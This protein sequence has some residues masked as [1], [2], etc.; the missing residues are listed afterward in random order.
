MKEIFDYLRK[1]SGGSL[2][3][4]QVVA[5]DQLIAIASDTVADML[6]IA[7]DLVKQVSNSGIN[8]ICGFEGLKLK[9]YDDS[10][11]VWTIGFGTTIYPNGIKVKKGDICTLEQAKAYMAHDLKKFESAVNSAVAVPINQ[12]QFDALVSLAYNIGTGAFKESTLLKK[13][14]ESDYK[15][16][17]AQF[18]VW[19]KA[20]GKVMPGL[21]NRRAV[22]RKL[23]EKAL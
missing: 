3:Q 11:G 22:E 17:A 4:K 8:L 20:G 12:N 21:V 19:N 2:T 18:A 6:G 13:L 9:A 14:N 1:I 23:F 15:A 16:A 5:T 7:V 10:V